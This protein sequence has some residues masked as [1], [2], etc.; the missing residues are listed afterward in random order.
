M[1]EINVL[2][3]FDNNYAPYAGISLTSLLESNRDAGSIHVFILGFGLESVTED[4]LR[5]TA[6]KYNREIT[7]IDAK[8]VEDYIREL[9]MPSYRGAGIAVARLFVTKYMPED[10]ERLLYLDSDTVIV[11]DISE[12]VEADLCKNA[13][14]MVCDSVGRDYK[15]LYGFK[16]NEDYYNGGMIVYDLP[17]WRKKKCSERIEDHIINVRNRYEALDQDLINIVLKGEITRLDL[18]Y[19]LQPFHLVYSPETYLGVY[20]KDGYYTEA[21]IVSAASS[22]VILHAFRYLGM[23]P[24]HTD[25]IHPCSE[26]FEHY[27]SISEWSDTESVKLADKPI[28]IRIERILQKLLPGRMFLFVFRTMFRLRMRS[29]EKSAEKGGKY[30]NI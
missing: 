5:R 30:V 10:V 8:P 9:D 15:R 29:I 21:E 19:N 17:A 14:G 1:S 6:G 27:K 18:R 24:W 7:F 11:G 13:V 4:K 20:G 28:V 23:F 16:D 22:P 25:S 12:L 3:P 26:R 2:Y